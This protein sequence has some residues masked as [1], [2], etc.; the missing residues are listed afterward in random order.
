ML[1]GQSTGEAETALRLLERPAAESGFTADA[2]DR[3]ACEEVQY[4]RMEAE[5]HDIRIYAQ[6]T[7]TQRHRARPQRRTCRRRS[8]WA[9]KRAQR[10]IYPI[11]WTQQEE[12][13]LENGHKKKG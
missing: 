7:R 6:R 1:S 12:G 9:G 13:F 8:Y 10:K 5:V 11:K 3:C 2:H 4:G